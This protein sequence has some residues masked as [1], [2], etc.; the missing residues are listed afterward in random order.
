MVRNLSGERFPHWATDEQRA[1]VRSRMR[2]AIVDW[3]PQA[4][5][6][7]LE[8]LGEVER[9]LFVE[10]HMAGQR[11][12]KKPLQIAIAHVEQHSLSFRINDGEHLKFASILPGMNVFQAYDHVDLADNALSQRL[13]F[14][15][16]ESKGYLT[17]DPS[18][19]GTGLRVSLLLF[20]P[21]LV[22]AEKIGQV[23]HAVRI[24]GCESGGFMGKGTS[25][26]ACIFQIHNRITLGESE[27]TILRRLAG[28]CEALVEQELIARDGMEKA[29][30]DRF[31]DRMAR[32]MALLCS[33]RVM[34]LHEALA[35]LG[36]ARLGACQGYIAENFV[37]KIDWL[38]T[39]IMPTHLQLLCGEWTSEIQ[40]NL[41]RA[42]RVRRTFAN[43]QMLR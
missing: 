20:L 41:M 42:D 32:V 34:P 15:F 26:D 4:H 21:A 31:S 13:E 16:D 27:E 36:Q 24:L 5:F 40:Q 14:A 9:N 33:A 6:W 25:P 12:V 43:V 7:S 35:L 37:E 11:V 19:A 10:R 22:A 17:A 29:L 8:N 38:M 1:E 39:A 3:A 23:A 28:V 30:A 18:D 2:S